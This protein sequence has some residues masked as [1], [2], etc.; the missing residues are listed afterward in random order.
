MRRTMPKP[1]KSAATIFCFTTRWMFLA[2][3][4]GAKT[5]HPFGVDKRVPWTTSRITGAPEPPAPYA[6]ETAFPD[7]RFSEPVEL[8]NAPGSDR[9]FLIQ[10]KGKILSFP[11]DPA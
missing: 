8:V 6:I 9:L 11:A 2:T 5:A 1:P 4:Q 10:L 7:L 3:V